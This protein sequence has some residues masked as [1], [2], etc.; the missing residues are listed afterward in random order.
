MNTPAESCPLC[1]EPVED[2]LHALVHTDTEDPAHFECV[3]RAISDGEQLES[4]E[5]VC[6]IGGG[7]FGIVRPGRGR[8]TVRIRKRIPYESETVVAQWRIEQVR[9]L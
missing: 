5:T 3:L 1:S 4:G 6:Y 2:L 7:V 9:R 8:R